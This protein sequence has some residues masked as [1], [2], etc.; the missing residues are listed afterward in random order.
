MVIVLIVSEVPDALPSSNILSRHLEP[1]GKFGLGSNMV[2]SATSKYAC[3]SPASG[4][5]GGGRGK[6]RV[7]RF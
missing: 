3:G 7:N 2:L 6:Q 1:F 5:C 4:Q